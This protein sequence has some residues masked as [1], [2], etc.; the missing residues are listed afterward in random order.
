MS[1]HLERYLVLS[2]L[3]EMLPRTVSAPLK[4]IRSDGDSGTMYPCFHHR[5]SLY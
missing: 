4:E 2:T 1:M 5:P 3:I